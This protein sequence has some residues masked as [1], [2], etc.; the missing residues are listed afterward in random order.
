[1]SISLTSKSPW[2]C[3]FA[4]I[5]WMPSMLIEAAYASWSGKALRTFSDSDVR[6]DTTGRTSTWHWPTIIG[7]TCGTPWKR[8][9]R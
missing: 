8:P 7:I 3:S 2:R 6:P 1:M 5:P 4:L 9:G